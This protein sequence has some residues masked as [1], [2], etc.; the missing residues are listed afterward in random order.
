MSPATAKLGFPRPR[1]ASRAY[2]ADN[3]GRSP[4]VAMSIK[5]VGKVDNNYTAT[6]RWVDAIVLLAK[7]EFG[8]SGRYS[9]WLLLFSG[10]KRWMLMTL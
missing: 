5:V 1:L 3:K 4:K 6:G 9:S 2:C 10:L 8:R 7:G